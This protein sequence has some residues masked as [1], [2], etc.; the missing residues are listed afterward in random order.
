MKVF[1]LFLLLLAGLGAG[2][3]T[4]SS[5]D[6][7]T[8][9]WGGNGLGIEATKARVTLRMPCETV[10]HNPEPVTLTSDGSF[11]FETL[12]RSF[13]GDV[14][15]VVEGKVSGRRLTAV[16]TLEHARPPGEQFILFH[17]V[18]PDFTDFVCLGAL[19]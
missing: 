7:L 12:L 15:V 18:Q 16:V 19:R 1:S 8:G 13:Y 17:G 2:C 10:G 14:E 9:T 4:D 3:A 5:D 11:E 6:L